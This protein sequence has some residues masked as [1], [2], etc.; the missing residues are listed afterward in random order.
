MLKPKS[1][2]LLKLDLQLFSEDALETLET[3]DSWES[4]ISEQLSE[5]E[6]VD[7]QPDQDSEEQLDENLEE[8]D[9]TEH[10]DEPDSDKEKD[11]EQDD[12]EEKPAF[13]DDTEIELGEDKK[14]VKLSEL[15]NGY[16]RQSDYTKKTQA[17]SEERKV[18]EAEKA[19]MEPVKGWLDYINQN[20]Y[21][22]QQINQAIDQWNQSGV[23][24]IEEVLADSQ[25]GK[26]INH[27]MA[28]NSRL[29]KELDQAQGDY[30]T[31]KF[32]ADMNTLLSELKAEYG[33]L[34]TSE[35]EE[36]L[37]KQARDEGLSK[38]V[39]KRIAKGDLA[40]QKLEQSQKESK[41]AEAKTKQKL[42]ETK[43]PPQPKN[44]GQQPAP[45]E[46]DT[47]GDWLSIFKQATAGQ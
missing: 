21:L 24:P 12:E 13:D 31:T 35:Y 34:V 29:Q 25:A 28:E 37:R 40:E 44:K 4:Y 14:P 17:L 36:S 5:A 2:R 3:N 26:Y 19:E 27:L 43:L 18:F 30:Q 46:I 6:S 9:V 15:K 8:K 38:E 39:L 41:K 10:E 7:E 33:D 22:F 23:L 47:D 20:P 32:D 1:P 16:L 42:R 11:D 45:K